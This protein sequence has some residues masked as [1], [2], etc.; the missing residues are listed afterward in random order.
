M[1]LK[2]EPSSEPLHISA[3]WLFLNWYPKKHIVT[4]STP[5]HELDCARIP[6]KNFGRAA[7]RYVGHKKT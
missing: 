5:G 6:E 4:S 7:F 1:S 2:Y 3:K